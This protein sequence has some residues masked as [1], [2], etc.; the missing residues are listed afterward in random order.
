LNY[1]SIW[2]FKRN[3]KAC[4]LKKREG[5]VLAEKEAII[6]LYEARALDKKHRF[7][8]ALQKYGEA[9]DLDE[10]L[11]KAWF[12]KFRLHHQLEQ[13]SEAA[14]CAQKA[15]EIDVKWREFITKVQKKP[16]YDRKTDQAA[17]PQSQKRIH[18]TVIPP[19]VLPILIERGD[20]KSLTRTKRKK[21][22]K[23]KLPREFVAQA[24]IMG[25]SEKFLVGLGSHASTDVEY[26]GK[27][28]SVSPL[29]CTHLGMATEEIEDLGPHEVKNLVTGEEWIIEKLGKKL[30]IHSH[31]E[32]EKFPDPRIEDI[33]FWN[34][35]LLTLA[36]LGKIELK[37]LFGG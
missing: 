22:K 35:L 28:L 1:M 9:I 21:K 31:N 6:L 10:K 13:F 8:E 19:E 16:K 7:E 18:L 4:F 27:I 32:P 12:Y 33:P 29:D 24:A 11:G 17:E 36:A 5:I 30:I 20:I 26:E 15:T 3:K 23:L 25:F 14:H 37:E 2:N 34:R